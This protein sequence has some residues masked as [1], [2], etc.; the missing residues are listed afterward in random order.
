MIYNR[1]IR[2]RYL[3]YNTKLDK[4]VGE[5]A[6]NAAKLFSQGLDISKEDLFFCLAIK[7]S[8]FYI[9]SCSSKF[10]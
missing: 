7:W 10:G 9:S 8:N 5:A 2:P 6:N 3:K 4:V 1:V